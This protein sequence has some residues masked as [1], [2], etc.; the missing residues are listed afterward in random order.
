MYLVGVC[1]WYFSDCCWYVDYCVGV[2]F[3]GV[4]FCGGGDYFCV[5][6]GWDWGW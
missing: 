1:F 3:D 6:V 5:V 4:V 2:G